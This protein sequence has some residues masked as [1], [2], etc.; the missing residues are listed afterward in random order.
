MAKTIEQRLQDK[1]LG[2]RQIANSTNTGKHEVYKLD[3]DEV[4]GLYS[5]I[6]S[7]EL[8]RKHPHMRGWQSVTKL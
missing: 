3:T 8:L 5:A 7:L 1:G 2:H 4:V 6:E